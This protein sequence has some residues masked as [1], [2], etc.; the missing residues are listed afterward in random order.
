MPIL[1]ADGDMPVDILQIEGDEPRTQTKSQPDLS[2]CQYPD[3]EGLSEV[4]EMTV[5]L[6]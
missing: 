3:L 6:H 4:V 2:D 1:W 5:V